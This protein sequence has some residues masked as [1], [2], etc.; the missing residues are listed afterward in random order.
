[1]NMRLFSEMP[2][3][4]LIVFATT[5]LSF[6]QTIRIRVL[7]SL[8]HHADSLRYEGRYEEAL[9]VLLQQYSLSRSIYGDRTLPCAE[10]LTRIGNARTH[11]GDDKQAEKDLR[12][13][14]LIHEEKLDPNSYRLSIPLTSLGLYCVSIGK[15]AEAR[16]LIER[17]LFI[18]NRH[19]HNDPGILAI[20]HR[21]MGIL[22]AA[23][24][25]NSRAELSY[26]SALSFILQDGKQSPS[27]ISTVLRHYAAFKDKVADIETALALQ[28]RA[29]SLLST[30][31]D[32]CLREYTDAL[33]EYSEILSSAGRNIEA[34]E[35]QFQVLELAATYESTTSPSYARK[36]TELADRHVHLGHFTE[37]L[38]LLKRIIHTYE[39]IGR[40]GDLAYANALVDVVEVCVLMDKDT[41]IT[42]SAERAYELVSGFYGPEHSIAARAL[43]YLGACYARKKLFA[44]AQNLISRSIVI[45]KKN[46]GSKHP[47]IAAAMCHLAI[48]HA[49]M[50]KSKTAVLNYQQ[51]ITM[52]KEFHHYDENYMRI[53]RMNLL[54]LYSRL[55]LSDKYNELLTE[56]DGAK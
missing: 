54:G 34:L 5:G 25:S 22:Y 49:V 38:E 46:Y 8:E 20:A 30:N 28:K 11:L 23:I 6:A 48:V 55:G 2:V 50:G 14:L 18:V 10:V 4:F 33:S 26:Q 53:A 7:D 37:A 24:D 45:L 40:K 9:K 3:W 27:Q 21:N 47:S 36:L 51:A 44:K 43:C 19:W 13:S 39:N 29:I 12:T 17:N 31:M 52:L 41:S 35:V 15:F 16:K 42:K 56:M 32:N 1:M